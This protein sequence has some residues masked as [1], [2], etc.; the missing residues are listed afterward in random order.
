MS[1]D[2]KT[3]PNGLLKL[4]LEIG[5]LVIFFV[6]FQYGEEILKIPAVFGV[7]EPIT[8]KEAL[9]GRSGPLYV[10]TAAFMVAITISLAV[11]WALTRSL[12][13]MAVITAILVIVFGGLTLWLQNDTF[14]KM[15]P[16]ILYTAFSIVL[17]FG[18]LQGRS[19]LK[20][21]MGEAIPM[22]DRGWILFTQRWIGF[23]L[24]LAI[25]NEVIW[26]A[27]APDDEVWVTFKTFAI[28]PMTLAFVAFH[29][30]FMQR[31]VLRDDKETG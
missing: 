25:L 11:S 2:A 4:L 23:F 21:L 31:H 27:T 20:L 13:R 19:Y 9:E 16:T 22:T 8:S 3:E 10:S 14:F 12:P 26:R 5:P 17:G 15:K 6:T 29:W 30:P 18:L 24:F 7:L 28:L 1:E